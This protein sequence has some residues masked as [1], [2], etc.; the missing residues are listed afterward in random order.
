MVAGKALFLVAALT[1]VSPGA[2]A[3]APAR[4]DSTLS[5]SWEALYDAT[6]LFRREAEVFPWNDPSDS[7]HISDRAVLMLDAGGAGY[8]L[9][10]KASTG[11]REEGLGT[12][13]NRIWLEQGHLSASLAGHISGRLFIRER[14]FGSP[15]RLSFPVSDDSPFLSGSTAGA[16]LN[17]E[18]GGARLRYTGAA[19]RGAGDGLDNAGFP[20]LHGAAGSVNTI[21]MTAE[22]SRIYGEMTLLEMRSVRYGDASMIRGGT[23]LRT[24]G[25]VLG[26][27]YALSSDDGWDGLGG[28]SGSGSEGTASILPPNAYLAAGVWGLELDAGSAGR[29]GFAP[30]YRFAGKDFAVGP[31]EIVPGS[32]ESFLDL[33]WRHPELSLM[34]DLD[35]AERWRSG[36]ERSARSAELSIWTRFRGGFEARE[37][38]VLTRGERATLALG[39]TDDNGLSRVSASARLDDAGGGNDLSF[40]ADAGIN[41][42]R[43]WLV[44]GTLYLERSTRGFYS[45]DIEIRDG[46]R[47]LLRV[48]A[49]TLMPRAD[50]MMLDGAAPPSP[51]SGER[52]VSVQARFSLGGIR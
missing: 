6:A 8:G 26:V 29:Y 43:R 12:G 25:A 16:V 38:V 20:P 22:W 7:S 50:S 32:V 31:G 45:A 17:L 15:S 18:A 24:G 21:S 3:E 36:M 1:A 40:L 44:G 49:G 10:L 52:F 35:L 30:G 2:S 14:M 19:V 11:V 46:R 4:S 41:L 37:T 42:G 39:L 5:C 27:E 13:E 51:V 23:G 9:F 48:S 33:W 47:F 34:V 28:P